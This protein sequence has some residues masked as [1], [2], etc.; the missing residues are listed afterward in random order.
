[1]G[2]NQHREHAGR[3]HHT[4]LH[5]E[6]H[7]LLRFLR[8]RYKTTNLKTRKNMPSTTIYIVRLPTGEKRDYFG[9]SKPCDNCELLLYKHNITRVKYT[10]I[11]DGI[12]VLCELKKNE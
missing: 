4:S 6:I 1:V 12:P 5:A 9:N 11:I 2:E 7:A 3:C 10:N 8:I